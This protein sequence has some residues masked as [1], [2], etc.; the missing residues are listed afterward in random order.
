M[1]ESAFVT[2][3][4]SGISSKSS[5]YFSYCLVSSAWMSSIRWRASTSCSCATRSSSSRFSASFSARGNSFDSPDSAEARLCS[6]ARRCCADTNCN[7]SEST[8][9]IALL[10]GFRT[11]PSYPS[12]QDQVQLSWLCRSVNGGR[13]GPRAAEEQPGDR[14]AAAGL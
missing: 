9:T 3:Y 2:K 11:A 7:S 5:Q 4:A 1:D 13:G 6:V 12:L 8:D 10:G 14:P